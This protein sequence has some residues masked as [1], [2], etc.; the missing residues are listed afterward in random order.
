MLKCFYIYKSCLY[1]GMKYYL[2][3]MIKD[4]SITLNR[5]NK[6]IDDNAALAKT[7]GVT[8]HWYIKEGVINGRIKKEGV[9]IWNDEFKD[10]SF[11][12]NYIYMHNAF[13]I[14]LI[15]EQD[16]QKLDQAALDKVRRQDEKDRIQEARNEYRK[17]KD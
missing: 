7:L 8:L 16:R 5:I 17:N 1:F 10:E 6:L 15:Q 14:I 3:P 9:T 12:I 2:P 13:S 4:G 11:H